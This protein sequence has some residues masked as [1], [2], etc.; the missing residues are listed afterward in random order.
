MAMN[1]EMDGGKI[2]PGRILY[3][4]MGITEGVGWRL[5]AAA[6]AVVVLVELAEMLTFPGGSPWPWHCAWTRPV[7][8]FR[9]DSVRCSSSV[10]EPQVEPRHF[11]ARRAWTSRPRSPEKQGAFAPAGGFCLGPDIVVTEGIF[12]YVFITG[13]FR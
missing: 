9:V 10:E 5:E 6:A 12:S 13:V 11:W 1:L 2:G 8:G 4:T 7:S 3:M